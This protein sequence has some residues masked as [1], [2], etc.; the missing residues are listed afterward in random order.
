VILPQPLSFHQAK[1]VLRGLRKKESF[2]RMSSH[3]PMKQAKASMRFYDI[4]PK[5]QFYELLWGYDFSIKGM[6]TN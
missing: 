3:I 4:L 1:L 2:T 6:N 5:E